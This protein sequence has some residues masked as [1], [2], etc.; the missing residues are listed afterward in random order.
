MGIYIRGMKMPKSC[1]EC[2]AIGWQYVFEC[3]LDDVEEGEK[4]STCPLGSAA[5]VRP[6]VHGE[7]K[8]NNDGSGACSVCHFTQSSVWDDDGWQNFC[9]HCGADMRG[10][11]NGESET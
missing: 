8:L 2:L 1:G 3:N 7:W 6:V 4:L 9:G 5:D 11:G 10:F